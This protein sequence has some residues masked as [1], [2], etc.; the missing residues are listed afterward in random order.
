[1]FDVPS[2]TFI[3]YQF[4]YALPYWI[5]RW[6][7]WKRDVRLQPMVVLDNDV[8]VIKRGG[9]NNAHN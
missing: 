6:I 8:E 9:A 7:F 1:M 4:R 3:R 2:S 5:K